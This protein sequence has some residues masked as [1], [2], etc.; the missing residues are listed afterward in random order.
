M[1]K[2]TIAQ[3]REREV[4]RLAQY[5]EQNP[6]AETIREAQRLMNSFYRLAGLDDRLLYLSNN[7]RTCN[8]RYTKTLE[9]KSYRWWQRLSAEFHA[10]C[11]FKLEYFG[12]LPTITDGDH[13][14]TISAH[15]YN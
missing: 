6:S 4:L 10:F 9:D 3:M 1:A 8:S 15:Y 11:G 12:H 14:Q 7:E 13:R 2:M 5:K